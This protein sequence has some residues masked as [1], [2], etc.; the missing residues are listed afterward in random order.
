MSQ[1]RW[2]WTLAF[3][4]LAL[5]SAFFVVEKAGNPRWVPMPIVV[6]KDTVGLH[7]SSDSSNTWHEVVPPDP[8][9]IAEHL[10]KNYAP[11]VIVRDDVLM[12][13]PEMASDLELC[14]NLVMKT[15]SELGW[16]Y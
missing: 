13:S 14:A 15:Y 7:S 16:D 1:R 10:V 2:K 9:L 12:V 11:S 5:A 8:Q 3:F 4:V 6:Y